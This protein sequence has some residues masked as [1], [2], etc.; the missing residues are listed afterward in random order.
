MLLGRE[1]GDAVPTMSVKLLVVLFDIHVG[2]VRRFHELGKIEA[3]LANGYFQEGANLNVL[4]L[5]HK[6]CTIEPP[7]TKTV[8]EWVT[9]V[10]VQ[11]YK[12][13]ITN[14]SNGQELLLE[15]CL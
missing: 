4:K 7:A 15:H 1:C 9:R 3:I 14:M 13:M 10:F 2:F 11:N 6:Y 12:I 5:V 8:P